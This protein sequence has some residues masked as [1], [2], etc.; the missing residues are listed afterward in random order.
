MQTYTKEYDLIFSIG[1]GCATSKQLRARELQFLSFPFDWLFQINSAPSHIPALQKCFEEDFKNWLKKENLEP[2]IGDERGT[3]ELEHQYKDTENGF[4]YIHDFHFSIDDERE[5]KKVKAKYKRRINRLLNIIKKSKNV[6][7][8]LDCKY[9]IDVKNCENLLKSLKNKFSNTNFDFIAMNFCE[10]KQEIFEKD[11]ILIY[12]YTRSYLDT[13]YFGLP[14]EWD[15]LNGIKLSKAGR[16]MQKQFL[17]N[18]NIIEIKK[19]KRGLGLYLF[20]N[21]SSIIRLNILF[22]SCRFDFSIGKIK[23]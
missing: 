19:L 5:Y 6:L 11:N 3:S 4:R 14:V 9:E 16:L 12:K 1:G 18:N 10:K 21:I 13:D 20:K 7:L 8:I 17:P 2:L 22:L 15:F 23:D